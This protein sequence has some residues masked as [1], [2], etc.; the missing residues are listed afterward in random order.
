[1]RESGQKGSKGLAHKLL[2]SCGFGSVSQQTDP[3]SGGLGTLASG[4]CWH[5]ASESWIFWKCEI[6]EV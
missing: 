6:R 4:W 3:R 5:F 1:M 2:R